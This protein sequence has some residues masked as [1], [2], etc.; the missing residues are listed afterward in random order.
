M[1]HACPSGRLLTQG[2][3]VSQGGAAVTAVVAED[4]SDRCMWPKS[5]PPKVSDASRLTETSSHSHTLVTAS[6]Q[7]TALLTAAL[8]E[9]RRLPLACKELTVAAT[10]LAVKQAIFVCVNTMAQ[11][12][13]LCQNCCPGQ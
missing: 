11:G 3:T 9:C 2:S 7:C 12:P 5:A 6:L 8:M 10:Q 4:P 13:I 1:W